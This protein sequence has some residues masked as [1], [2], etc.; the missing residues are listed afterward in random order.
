MWL[1]LAGWALVTAAGLAGLAAV[2]R[3][4]VV[5]VLITNVVILAAAALV[6]AVLLP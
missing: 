6:A 5:P 1:A 3:R 4:A 2:D